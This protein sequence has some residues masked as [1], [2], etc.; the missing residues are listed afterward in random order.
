LIALVTVTLHKTFGKGV[1]RSVHEIARHT[2]IDIRYYKNIWKIM[3]PS[4]LWSNRCW[5][6]NFFYITVQHATP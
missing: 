5:F 6:H 2:K 1:F 4:N 3:I